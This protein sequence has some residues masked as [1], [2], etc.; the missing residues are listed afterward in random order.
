MLTSLV[1]TVALVTFQ[2]FVVRRTGSIA[3]AA[4]AQHYQADVLTNLAVLAAIAADAYAGWRLADPILGLGVVVLILVNVWSLVV[5]SFDVLLDRELA[6]DQ[7]KI[8]ES[9][10]HTHPAVK[11]MHDL[12]TRSSG[13]AEFIQFHLELDPSLSLTAA[14]DITDAV[15]AKVKERFPRAEV[16][17]HAD[18]EGVV[19]PRDPY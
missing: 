4:D 12:R 1:L 6:T 14:H 17:I 9:L 3:I 19:E 16:I 11:G 2:R 7:R 8:I 10:A 18:P 13:N 15:E 5:K